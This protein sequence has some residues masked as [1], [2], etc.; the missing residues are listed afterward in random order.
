MEKFEIICKKCGSSNIDCEAEEIWVE[1][2]FAHMKYTL[3]CR[4]CGN[5]EK[6]E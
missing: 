2:E 1:H 4:Y 6:C 5:S 3:V